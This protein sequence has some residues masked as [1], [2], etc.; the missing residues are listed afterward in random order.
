MKWSALCFGFRFPSGET[1]LLI[2]PSMPAERPKRQ[3]VLSSA[4]LQPGTWGA[5]VGELTIPPWHQVWAED[6][7]NLIPHA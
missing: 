4:G 2:D 3:C 6:H 1:N 7:G 5:T